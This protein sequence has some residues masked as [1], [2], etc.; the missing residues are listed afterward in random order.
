MA[1]AAPRPRATPKK[2]LQDVM[3]SIPEEGEGVA[4]AAVEEQD[5]APPPGRG[6]F[7]ESEPAEDAPPAAPRPA[8][9]PMNRDDDDDRRGEDRRR[10]FEGGESSAIDKETHEKYE[11]VKR[12]ELHITDLQKMSVAELHEVAKHEGIEEY[13]GLPKEDAE[14]AS[15]TPEEA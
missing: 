4:A 2:K 8:A 7:V 9:P 11:R 6:K 15:A 5:E 14:S 1:K 3:E 12:G 13:A 10:R